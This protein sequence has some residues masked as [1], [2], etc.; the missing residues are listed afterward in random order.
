MGRTK[1][2]SEQHRRVA[3]LAAV[4]LDPPRATLRAFPDANVRPLRPQH[5]L[6]PGRRRG[7]L[8]RL[9]RVRPIRLIGHA[10]ELLRLEVYR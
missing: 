1:V 4:S 6:R 10:E 7:W 3:R 8:V 2:S 5:D 9:C